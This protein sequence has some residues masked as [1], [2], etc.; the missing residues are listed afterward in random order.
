MSA[1]RPTPHIGLRQAICTA[2]ILIFKYFSK[3]L[4]RKI[5]FSQ[6]AGLQHRRSDANRVQRLRR[7][8]LQQTISYFNAN[9]GRAVFYRPLIANDLI[10]GR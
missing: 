6:E 3:K 8:S 2:K 10:N 1:S 5:L 9:L 7:S 4:L